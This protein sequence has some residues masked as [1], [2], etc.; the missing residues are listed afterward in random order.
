MINIY[1]CEDDHV[2]LNCWKRIIEKYLMIH[3]MDMELFCW[4][5][6]PS[7]LLTFLEKSDC[8]GLYFIDIDLNADMNGLELAGEIRK[9]DPRGYIV[10]I[11]THD[12]MAPLTF[13]LKV[14]AMDFILKDEPNRLEKKI[15]SCLEAA[16]TN[17]YR[18]LQAGNKVLVIK[19]GRDSVLMDQ[20]DIIFI[21][22]GQNSHTVVICTWNGMRRL[23]GTLK[24]IMAHLNRYFCYCSRS[25]IIN[26]KNA[27][28]YLPKERKLRMKNGAV[29]DVSF[30]MAG[31]IQRRL[32]ELG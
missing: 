9:Y 2:Q 13:K 30:R 23:P 1:L 14:E 3:N 18:Q 4:A 5:A 26:I 24:E 32:K 17:Y 28:V 12:E 27:E 22:C 31:E 20:D 25:A 11:T 21:T 6:G 29:C 7:D 19:D 10:F 15:C 16:N 8:V